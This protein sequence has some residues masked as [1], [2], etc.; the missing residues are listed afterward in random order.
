[1]MNVSDGKY[2]VKNIKPKA[3]SALNRSFNMVF[4]SKDMENKMFNTF[5]L[6]VSEQLFVFIT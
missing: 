5:K 3:Y 2:S 6:S 1:M 4:W